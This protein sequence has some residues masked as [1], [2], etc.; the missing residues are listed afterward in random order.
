MSKMYRPIWKAVSG[1]PAAKSEMGKPQVQR[2][3][4]AFLASIVAAVTLGGA[5]GAAQAALVS[6]CTGVSLPPSTI[7]TMLN[8]L[9]TPLAGALP[10]LGLNTIWAGIAAGTPVRLNVL[11]T[12]DNPVLPSA[13]CDATADSYALD[14][15]KGISIGGNKITGLGI[16]TVANAGETD[17]IAL[18]NG[19]TTNAGATNSIALGTNAS[20]GAAGANSVALGAGSAANIGAQA[21]YPAFGLTM[22]R[23]SVG[24][25][26][27]GSAGI[28]LRKITNV[29]PG[30]DPTDAVN[31]EQLQAAINAAQDDDNHHRD[32]N[33]HQDDRDHHGHKDD[34]DH[35]GNQDD[36]ERMVRVLEQQ[37]HGLQEQVA[38]L[39]T[40]LT[41]LHTRLGSVEAIAPNISLAS[42]NGHDTV[43]FSSVNTQVVNGGGSTPSGTYSSVSGV[44]GNATIGNGSSVTIGG[45]NTTSGD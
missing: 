35:Y 17:S 18:G 44:G 30:S 34:R 29:A 42:G 12:A 43:R 14:T 25:V 1:T 36:L 7:T 9:V 5:P 37:V 28:S 3:G 15:P 20:A 21:A 39:R 22:L 41:D 31:V 33:E 26:S 10:L 6:V 4:P 19:A 40:Q 13:V 11:D 23:T 8:P 24:E 38:A 45:G 27:V 16:T 2:R 32:H